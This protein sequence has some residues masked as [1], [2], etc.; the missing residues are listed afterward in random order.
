MS[1]YEVSIHIDSCYVVEVEAESKASAL[2]KAYRKLN[3]DDEFWVNLA[4]DYIAETNHVELLD[5][6]VA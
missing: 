2:V 4:Q 6:D 1:K 5:Q 3:N